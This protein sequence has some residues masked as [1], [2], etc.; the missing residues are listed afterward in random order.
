[1][2]HLLPF[3]LASAG[4]LMLWLVLNQTLSFGHV[5]LGVAAAVVGGWALAA[6]E[7]PKTRIRRMAAVLRL[8]A[9]VVADIIRSNVAVGRIVIGL[10][11]SRLTSGFVE[12]PLDLRNPYGLAV[13]ACIITST[14][15]TLWTKFDAATGML[16]IHVLDLI[17][18]S[19][20]LCTI[21]GRYERLLLEIF[22]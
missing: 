21:K 11:N 9:L 4:L 8:T 22:P 3:P 5:L 12:I 17:D 14:P 20:W 1:M 10:G 6:L 18:E 15:G 2:T 19:D 16:T 7:A 13:L